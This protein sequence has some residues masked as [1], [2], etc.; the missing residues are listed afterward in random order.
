MRRVVGEFDGEVYVGGVGVG[1]CDCL[2]GTV[3]EC[4]LAVEDFQCVIDFGVIETDEVFIDTKRLTHF[5]DEAVHRL[6]QPV[7]SSE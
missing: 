4:H 1:G 2:Y 3:N 5:G 7:T 6:I